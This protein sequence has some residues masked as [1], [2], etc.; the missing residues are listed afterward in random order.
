MAATPENNSGVTSIAKSRTGTSVQVGLGTALLD[1]L[2]DTGDE[3]SPREGTR[4]FPTPGP[5]STAMIMTAGSWTTKKPVVV[6]VPTA[7]STPA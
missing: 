3:C 7:S 4:S 2:A 1:V 5:A 6:S